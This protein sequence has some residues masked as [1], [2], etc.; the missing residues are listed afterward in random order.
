MED[1]EVHETLAVAD[2]KDQ[3]IYVVM[4]TVMDS[5]SSDKVTSRATAPHVL[6]VPSAGSRRGQNG[7]KLDPE[8]RVS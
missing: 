5:A 7:P 4:D 1:E 8:E 3:G 2:N 6:V